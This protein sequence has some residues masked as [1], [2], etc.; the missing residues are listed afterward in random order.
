MNLQDADF[1]DIAK[2]LERRGWNFLLMR[3]GERIGV[4]F[5]QKQ[6]IDISGQGDLPTHLLM[7]HQTA[8]HLAL[9]N[10]LPLCPIE[11]LDSKIVS[12][13]YKRLKKPEP[14]RKGPDWVQEELENG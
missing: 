7:L 14:K 8:E 3:A 4:G 2:E 11:G 1:K 6:A 12:E 13:E 9:K 10:G 5:E